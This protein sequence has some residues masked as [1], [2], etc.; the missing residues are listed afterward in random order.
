MSLLGIV[1][2]YIVASNLRE[3]WTLQKPEL[4]PSI[5][6]SGQP[7]L[8]SESSISR[9]AARVVLL[10]GIVLMGIGWW[11]AFTG[12]PQFRLSLSELPNHFAH[13]AAKFAGRIGLPQRCFTAGF[14][15]AGLYTYH[16][17]PPCRI[18]LD[19]RLE[20]SSKELFQRYESIRFK[21]RDGNP[22]WI[23]ELRDENGELPVVL[24][25]R[26]SAPRAIQ[27]VARTP[28]WSTVY[29]DHLAVVFVENSVAERLN[30]AVVSAAKP[31]ALPSQ[32]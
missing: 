27:N 24:L 5:P 17:C 20:S 3:R 23:E 11:P 18:F 19:G 4:A 2:G 15:T 12:A 26:T 10:A 14:G 1:C 31:D 22:L 8:I 7:A 21:M 9:F 13:D 28:G 29:S 32:E 30:L 6:Q 25:D 16:H